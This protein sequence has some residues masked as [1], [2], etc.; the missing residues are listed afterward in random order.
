M[1]SVP[2][3]VPP[4]RDPDPEVFLTFDA[5]VQ[6]EEFRTTFRTPWYSALLS[7]LLMGA[8]QMFNGQTR[9]G[10]VFLLAELSLLLYAW[11]HLRGRVV[12]D[13]LEAVLGSGLYSVFIG[14]VFVGGVAAWA[15]NV[16]DAYEVARF[17]SFIYD[18][19]S[20]LLDDEEEDALRFTS[21]RTQ[22]LRQARSRQAVFMA[23]VVVLYTAFV[24]ALGSQVG[25]EDDLDRLLGRLATSRNADLHLEAANF[26]LRLDRYDEASAE[27][28]RAAEHARDRRTREL[29]QE[30]LA[31]VERARHG[32]EP[33]IPTRPAATPV[34]TTPPGFE[35]ALPPTSP[36]AVDLTPPSDPG[37]EGP[38]GAPPAPPSVL[39][40]EYA[41]ERAEIELAVGNAAGAREAL[42]SLVGAGVTHP[43]LAW[44]RGEVARLDGDL[45]TARARYQEAVAL[46]PDLP[47]PHL[48]LAELARVSGSGSQVE[49]HLRAAVAA[50]PGDP[51]AVRALSDHLL[52]E[53]RAEQA[54]D[55][56]A[57]A[58]VERPDDHDLLYRSFVLSRQADNTERAAEAAKALARAEYRDGEVYVFLANR[59]L[60][61]D[62]LDGAAR[63]LAQLDRIDPGHPEAILL[64]GKVLRLQRK[65]A[66][67]VRLLQ[68]HVSRGSLEL[69]VVLA[70]A[71][72][73]ARDYEPGIRALE[74]AMDLHPPDAAALKLLGIL[75]K[76]RGDLPGALRAYQRALDV[77]PED[78]EALYLA[79]YI[80]YRTNQYAQGVE[81]LEKV[82]AGGAHF[83]ETEFYL[84]TCYEGQ[85]DLARARATY[86][87]VPAQSSNVAKAQQA[88]ARLSR[89]GARSAAPEPTPAPTGAAPRTPLPSAGGDPDDGQGVPLRPP[90]PQADHVS[91]E[92]YAAKLQEAEIAFRDDML[93]AALA[94]YDQVLEV[95][96]DHFR[97]HFQRGVILRR[98]GQPEASL[99]ALQVA[100]SLEPKHL[101]TLSELGQVLAELGRSQD[102]TTI[103]EEALRIDPKNLAVRYRL[104][105]LYETAVGNLDKAEEH[106][107]ALVWYH[108]EYLRAHEF[109]GN[110]Y[111][112]QRRYDRA[113][114]AFR[115]L[116]AGESGDHT[117][118]YK[119]SMVLAELG[120]ADGQRAEL[121][122]LVRDMPAD[123]K[124]RPNVVAD[125]EKLR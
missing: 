41:L 27:F 6:H 12:T 48:G 114:V 120:D 26:F 50:D 84:A 69:A 82:R 74:R 31:S 42:A 100:R 72:K 113:A 57:R 83:G 63:Y 40:L 94:L 54:H 37:P 66:E 111:F 16:Y 75:R 115:K 20:Q 90:P 22:G 18:R 123:H 53:G 68:P 116:L 105:I 17:V 62:E 76:R 104:G 51:D 118:R 2:E 14:A 11:D 88:L 1:A 122:T 93:P 7:G 43:R 73:E 32:G 10:M 124:Y 117:V 21:E 103:F 56:V 79:G 30:G 110:V 119:L 81:V 23:G 33:V 91:V 28:Q 29:A 78:R 96:P 98:A 65:P 15:F 9:R 89:P 106:Y 86:A 44:V 80:Y 109:L 67:A 107:Q 25:G 95:K 38:D 19:H 58:L 8:G 49:S 4:Q 61:R 85:G 108:P 59:A 24:F 112:K 34:G 77:A 45:D 71:A 121:E 70:Q 13:T 125:L 5:R 101:G 99:E 102:A 52:A 3:R 36:P 46:D 47:R 97:S 39:D 64:K 55:V 87:E 60:A 92:A 35:S